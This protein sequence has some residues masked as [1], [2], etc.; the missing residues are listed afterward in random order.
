MLSLGMLL[1]RGQP[2]T[3]D[4]WPHHMDTSPQIG[5]NSTHLKQ[6]DFYKSA[7]ATL[8]FPFVQ[9]LVESVGRTYRE[10]ILRCGYSFAD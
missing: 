8:Q 7:G 4:A 9:T 6:L 1:K 2:Q 5:T 10:D 3:S